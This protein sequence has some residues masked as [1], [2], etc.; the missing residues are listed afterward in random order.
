MHIYIAL[1][2]GLCQ[3]GY[4][5]NPYKGKC[6]IPTWMTSKK[7]DFDFGIIADG[8]AKDV[9]KAGLEKF[10]IFGELIIFCIYFYVYAYAC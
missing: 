10:L 2:L 3:A 7:S 8:V 5:T 4:S 9:A 1:S 6:S